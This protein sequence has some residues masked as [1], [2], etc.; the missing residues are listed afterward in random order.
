MKENRDNFN[1]YM[2][3]N[4]KHDGVTGPEFFEADYK[5]MISQLRALKTSPTVYTAIPPP[6]Y[7][8]GALSMNMTIINEL[9]PPL[10]EKI[11]NDMELPYPPINVFKALGGRELLHPDWFGDNCH[12]NDHGYAEI[13]KVVYATLVNTKRLTSEGAYKGSEGGSEGGRKGGKGEHK[14]NVTHSEVENEENY[15]IES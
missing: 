1:I 2:P 4:W 5:D 10:I 15:S 8:D 12:P 11:N 3:G 6:L 7:K 14:G 13:A 9:L